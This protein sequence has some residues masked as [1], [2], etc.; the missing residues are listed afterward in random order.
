M[1]KI[2]LLIFLVISITSCKK[3]LEE[4]PKDKLSENNF[5][6][7][8]PDAIS[9]VN[10]IY[11]PIRDNLN[12]NYSVMIDILS[13]YWYGR[14]STMP[15]SNYQGLDATNI[16]RVSN[17]WGYQYRS[18]RNANIAI[19]KISGMKI[20]G[21][22]K[23]ALVAEARFLRAYVYY[24]MV[25]LWGPIPLYLDTEPKDMSRKSEDEVYQAIIADLQTGETDLPSTP[26]EF[27]RPTKWSA[28][29]L[30]AEV[31]LTRGEWLL[32]KSKAQEVID[33]HI[34]GLVEVSVANDFDKIFGPSA[35]GTSEE[36]FYLKFSHEDGYGYPHKLLWYQ[37]QFSPFG[38][39]VTYG[40]PTNLFLNTWDKNDLRKQFNIFTQYINR[41][42][43]VTETLPAS[44]PILCSKYRDVAATGQNGFGNDRTVLRY[45]DV[46]LIYAEA[47]VLAENG[48]S[49]SALDC[50]NKIKRRAYGYPSGSVSPVDY[51]A[52]GWTVDSFRNTVIQERGYELFMEGKR[53]FDLKRLGTDKLKEL[54]LANKGMTVKDLHL[55]W[56]IPQQEIDTNPDINVADQNPGY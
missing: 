55:L 35:N 48:V 28:K 11:S 23:S 44:T 32:A 42:T 8:L 10:S 9:A 21:S 47:S 41:F 17:S 1:K 24:T 19:Q 29:A 54:V 52:G 56:P 13:D 20:A 45:A 22:D 46:L 38:S 5:Y 18:I 33:S 4:I 25:R 12:D 2:I 37:D 31:Y 49:S 27:G 43:G 39:Y 16:V 26:A 40:K 3:Y 34:F 51:P 6:A 30:L 36:I 50:L 15:M 53:W 7:A 14:G